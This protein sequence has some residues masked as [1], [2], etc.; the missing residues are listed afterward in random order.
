MIDPRELR[1]GNYFHPTVFCKGIRMP[2]GTVAK[3]LTLNTFQVLWLR[4]DQIEA[5]EPECNLAPYSEIEPIPLTEEWL[6]KLGVDKDW[7]PDFSKKLNVRLHQSGRTFEI[8]RSGIEVK[9]VHQL[10][11][12]WHVATGEELTI[13]E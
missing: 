13:K 12:I 7:L 10:Q 1:I 6:I 8:K 3:V 9:Y 2:M 4:Y 11:N 5:C